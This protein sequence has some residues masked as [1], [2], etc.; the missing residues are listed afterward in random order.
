MVKVNGRTEAE[1][2]R[3]DLEHELPAGDDGDETAE[4][5]AVGEGQPLQ[6]A[7]TSGVEAEIR[8][9]RAERDSLLDRLARS[10]AEFENARRRAGR[11][12][13]EFRDYATVDA[14]RS[15]LPALD[16]FERALQVKAEA[17]DFRSGVELIYKQL[18]DALSKLGV[19][20]IP[21]KGEQFD[22]R[23]HEAIELVET[24]D[25]PDHEVLEELQHGYKLKER[26]LRPAMVKV[27]KNPGK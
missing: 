25:A 6:A 20:R 7:E 1:R 21:A 18:Q 23:L 27:A 3:L 11:E 9:L 22:P 26:L 14:I 12:Q 8:K 2:A 16:S 17:G 13:Q 15:L 4:V 10:Q 24:T 5:A 19:H